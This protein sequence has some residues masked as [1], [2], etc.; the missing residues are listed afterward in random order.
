MTIESP[1]KSKH[2]NKA[3]AT[4]FQAT[5]VAIDMTAAMVQTA[6]YQSI[7][8]SAPFEP[9]TGSSSEDSHVKEQDDA[10]D[11]NTKTDHIN[12]YHVERTHFQNFKSPQACLEANRCVSMCEAYG[13]VCP[14]SAQRAAE[15]ACKHLRHL[16]HESDYFVAKHKDSN[17]TNEFVDFEYRVDQDDLKI[18]DLL[19]TG[20][21]CSVHAC[22]IPSLTKPG[23]ADALYAVK[24]LRRQCMCDPDIFKHGAADLALEAHF[25]QAL[26]HEHIIQIHAVPKGNIFDNIASAK[27]Y[28]YFIVL[29]RLTDTLDKRIEQWHAEQDKHH[30]SILSRWSHDFREHKRLELVE[31]LRVAYAIADALEYL[32]LRRVIFRDLKPDK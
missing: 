15:Y 3:S 1:T 21:F 22:T 30:G 9:S 6:D 7:L 2:A 8:M 10:A 16:F 13:R 23:E 25:L 18:G 31:R 5:I 4:S 17:K 12:N 27:P 32:H 29:D 14:H 20:G 11:C 26:Q 24:T 19:G 28:G